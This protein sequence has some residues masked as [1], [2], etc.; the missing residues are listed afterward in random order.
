MNQLITNKTKSKTIMRQNLRKRKSRLVMRAT[1]LALCA[2]IFVVPALAQTPTVLMKDGNYTIQRNTG[3]INFYDSHGAS[4]QTNYWESWYNHNENFTFVFKPAVTGDKIKV[5][6]QPFRAYAEPADPNSA[7]GVDIG[8]WTLRLNEDYLTV[9]DGNGAV[10]ANEIATLTGNSQ[11]EGITFMSNGAMTFKFT[12]NERY[13]E[14]GWYATVELVTDGGMAPQAPFIQRSTCSDQVEIFPTTL[15]AHIIYSIGDNDPAPGDPLGP[16][17]YEYTGPI[18]FPEGTIPSTGFKVNAISQLDGGTVW[19]TVSHAIFYE[20]D[21]VPIPDADD[22]LAHTKI[23]RLTGT[24]TIVMTPAER[25]AGLNDTYEVRYTVSTNGTEP[26]DP[27]YNNS[28]LYTGPITCTVNGTIYKAKTFA[29]SCHNQCSE[30]TYR[31]E[32]EGIYA[33]APVIDLNAMTISATEGETTFD[34]LYTLDGSIPSV[35]PITGTYSAGTVNLSGLTPGQTVRAIAYRAN[36][37]TGHTANTNYTPSQVVSAI[38]VPSGGSGSYGTTILLDDREDHS[39]SYYSDGEQ[40]IHSLNPA[41]VKITYYGNGKMYTSTSANPSGSLSNATGVKVSASESE[42]TFIYLKTLERDNADGSGNVKYTVIPNPFSVRPKFTSGNTSYYTGFYGW[43]VKRLSGVTITGYS[44]G[45]IITSLEAEIEFVTSNE[46]GNEVDFEAVWARAYVGSSNL[47]SNVTYERNFIQLTENTTLSGNSVNYPVTYTSFD[48][49][50]G[51]GTKRTVTFGTRAN[52][53]YRCQ[54]N[55]KFENIT[56]AYRNDDSYVSAGGHNLTFGR[57]VTGTMSRVYGVHGAS[58]SALNYTIRLESGTINNFWLTSNGGYTFGSTV[59]TKAILGCDYDRAKGDDAKLSIAPTNT[60]IEGGGGTNVMSS[61]SN[62]N[63]LTYDWNVKSGKIQATTSVNTGDPFYLGHYISSTDADGTQYIGKRRLTMEGGE[64]GTVAGGCDAYGDYSTYAVNDGGWTVMIRMK[65]GIVNGSVY[66]AAVFTGANGDRRFVFT[67]GT[68][69]GWIAGGCNGTE[70]EGG[71]LY[72]DSYIYFGGKAKCDGTQTTQIGSSTAGNI[73]GAGS[74]NSGATGTNAT[75]GRVNN[76]NVVIA[77]EASVAQSVYGGG[78][79]GYVRN[80]NNVDNKSNIYVLGGTVSGSVFGG[81]NQQQG[82]IVNIWMKDGTVTGNLYGGS[83]TSG[84]VNY[85]A[86]IEMS[87]G[88][89][90]NVYGGGCGSSTIMSN[91]TKVTVTGGTINTNMYG[92]GENGD[93]NGNTVVSFEGGSVTD[94][95]GAGKGTASNV[96][97]GTTVNVKGGVVNGSVFGGGENGTVAFT[98]GSGT[99]NYQSIVTVSGGEVK[100]N[101]FGGGYKGTTQGKTTVNITGTWDGTVVRGDV[102]AGA[103]GQH[104]SIFVAGLK[105]LNISGGRIYGSVYGGS[106]DANDGNTLNATGGTDATSITNISGGRI[107]QHVFAAG[108]YGSSKGSVYAFIGLNAINDAPHHS[109]GYNYPKS[110]LLIGGSVW[111]GG[112]WGVFSGTFGPPT[113]SGNSNIYINGEG[114]STES[115]DPLWVVVPRAMLV[116]ANASSFSAIMA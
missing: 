20:S 94:V 26:A 9:Y 15:G 4:Q 48:P 77:D 89:A 17:T 114:Y 79:Y 108:Y 103:Y 34:I 65:G 47:N 28:T 75:V 66:G 43:R 49:A 27:T 32:V 115:N 8:Y 22:N 88:T 82:Q 14:E 105:T 12:S 84:T 50:T 23:E 53:Y 113:I 24:N 54:Q 38:Y 30:Q 99:T 74:G 36:N 46:E 106:R 112:D 41:D 10:D 29:V 81:S 80:E 96:A 69:R 11:M 33:P 86:T 101:V 78:N 6:F 13:R 116:K 59:T 68:V 7:V 2:L 60:F 71:E 76:S 57:G 56:L 90:T 62:R 25:P 31:L 92:G 98:N 39:W 104:G 58:T 19:S 110:S 72:G 97:Q 109:T 21:R 91:N 70:T 3:V 5:T 61:S 37:D 85:L 87:G 93:V 45:D 16:D 67:G 83:N 52:N 102:F 40:P 18:S 35:D 73:F 95:Y 107:D 64:I 55:V 1:F 63:N 44:E 111:A 100:N 51:N 42:D